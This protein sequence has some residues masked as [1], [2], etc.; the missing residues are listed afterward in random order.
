M[1]K[2]N[3]NMKGC[4]MENKFL[5]HDVDGRSV[6]LLK[7]DDERALLFASLAEQALQLK[8]QIELLQEQYDLIFAQ[9]KEVAGNDNFASLEYRLD[10][11]TR[12]GSIDYKKLVTV[13][14]DIL[15]QYRRP[16]TTSFVL[17]RAR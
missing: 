9:V 15:E 8:N 5:I 2:L 17:S 12:K 4:M 10:K 3:N 14:A 1:N 7:V 16:S 11:I 13:S 6:E